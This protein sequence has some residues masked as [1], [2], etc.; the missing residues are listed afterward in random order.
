MTPGHTVLSSLPDSRP[1]ALAEE[2]LMKAGPAFLPGSL[3]RVSGN[4]R[5]GSACQSPASRAPRHHRRVLPEFLPQSASPNKGKLRPNEPLRSWHDRPLARS[6]L[7]DALTFLTSSS[8][9]P[10]GLSTRGTGRVLSLPAIAGWLRISGM[11]RVRIFG[12]DICTGHPRNSVEICLS[13]YS[14]RYANDVVT[15][16]VSCKLRSFQNP[17]MAPIIELF[18]SFN[19][20]WRAELESA[21]EGKLGDS[22]NSIV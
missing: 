16:F 8:P 13:E 12:T 22:I 6:L 15:N 10:T 21:T 4:S 7:R 20:A 17:K 18:G 14:R 9:R 5:R 19:P 3:R 11:K 1:P 2:F